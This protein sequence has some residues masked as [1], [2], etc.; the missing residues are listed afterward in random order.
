DRADFFAT[1]AEGIKGKRAVGWRLVDAVYPTSQF[2]ERV[3]RRAVAW[4]G[5]SDRP[6]SGPGVQLGPLLPEVA[7]DAVHYSHVRLDIDRQR[8]VGTLVVRAPENVPPSTPNEI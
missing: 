7:D 4:A 2:K 6:A 1:V 8:R 3:T 5:M